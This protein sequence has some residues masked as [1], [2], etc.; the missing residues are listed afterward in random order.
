MFELAF[1]FV[2]FCSF[3]FF[4]SFGVAFRTLRA[5]GGG[6]LLMTLPPSPSL[7]CACVS[8]G[9]SHS[10]LQPVLVVIQPCVLVRYM[11]GC[12][13]CVCLLSSSCELG[14]LRR[15]LWRD[16]AKHTQVGHRV[17]VVINHILLLGC[18]LLPALCQLCFR[19]ANRGLH[20]LHDLL[21][22]LSR[23]Y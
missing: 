18:F 9:Y 16:F 13:L 2:L 12:F 11:Y 7:V 1:S 21:T 22:G 23:F 19:R 3:C 14:V 20:G 6:L 17:S 15:L 8:H 5:S 10:C 4:G